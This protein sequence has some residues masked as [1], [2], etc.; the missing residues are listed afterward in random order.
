MPL[1][2]GHTNLYVERPI[3]SLPLIWDA[4]CIDRRFRAGVDYQLWFSYSGNRYEPVADLCGAIAQA[5]FGW[6]V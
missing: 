1:T 6:I 5:L 4:V 2:I 3:P